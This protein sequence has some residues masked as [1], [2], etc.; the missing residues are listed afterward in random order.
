ML[1]SLTLWWTM[2]TLSP[3]GTEITNLLHIDYW[4]AMRWYNFL[5]LLTWGRFELV[6][7]RLKALY[8]ITK[9]MRYLLPSTT[10]DSFVPQSNQNKIHKTSRIEKQV[11]SERIYDSCEG[12]STDPYTIYNWSRITL[13]MGELH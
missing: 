12:W 10:S 2:M 5:S 8:L 1:Y 4:T 13:T 9:P 3:L 6:T 11:I 7:K